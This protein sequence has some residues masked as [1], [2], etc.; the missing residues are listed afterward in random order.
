[1]DMKNKRL[2]ARINIKGGMISPINMLKIIYI[3]KKNEIKYFHF[4]SRQDIIMEVSLSE[5]EN[6]R[7]ELMQYDVTFL[8]NKNTPGNHQNI[9][10]SYLVYDIL[11]ST[12]WISSG[13]YL[14]I[15]N[16]FDYV[17]RLRINI[18]DPKQNLVPLLYGELNFIA[19][20][21]ENLWHLHI[22][23]Q[24]SHISAIWPGLVFTQDIPGLSFQLE[25]ILTKNRDISIPVL[26]SK[27]L[28][29][30]AFHF[31]ETNGPVDFP[32]DFFPDYEG[33]NPMLNHDKFWAGFYWKNNRYDI[34]FM[35]VVTKLSYKSNLPGI[36]ITPWKSFLIKDIR[37]DD[38]IYWNQIIG[39]FG[40]NMRHSSFDLNW[41][42][43]LLSKQAL[44]LKTFITE[45]FNK[46]DI[47]TYG[48]TISI[49][50]N[51]ED[52]F[53]SIVIRIKPLV[54][55]IKK[56]SLLKKYEILYARHFNSNS[57][58]YILYK[59]VF[60]KSELIPQLVSLSRE[61]YIKL[62]TPKIKLTSHVKNQEK[63]VNNVHQC[64][65]CL[66][67]YDEKYG[68]PI[69]GIEKD[70]SFNLLPESY[71]CPTCDG[72]KSEYEEL[73]VKIKLQKV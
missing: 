72:P 61:F 53:T 71:T 59:T 27:V 19:S 47:R 6:I 31:A 38:L 49:L 40:I 7:K 10:S 41:H 63:T 32:E 48:L 50:D 54:R 43:P 58:S 45:R 37:K 44:R 68:D 66:T 14:D 21:K 17:P 1:M 55:L 22:N 28:K 15:F 18:T 56:I 70:T 52:P 11:P 13:T 39:Q 25:M 35:E 67:V 62:S 57:Q 51:N 9:T 42:L 73:N 30:N 64:K 4:G 26:I 20:K 23:I 16:S 65:N 34:S 29:M 36:C 46:I 60:S 33:I 69:K 12:F 2:L 5:K 3:A 24:S 8:Q